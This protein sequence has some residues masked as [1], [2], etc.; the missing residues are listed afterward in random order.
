VNA[1]VARPFLTLDELGHDVERDR[2]THSFPAGFDRTVHQLARCGTL[3][4]PPF[5][6]G[7]APCTCVVCEDW[8]VRGAAWLKLLESVSDDEAHAVLEAEAMADLG[9]A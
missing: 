8:R 9:L 1:L 6:P 7:D 2:V 3:V 4:Y 5:R